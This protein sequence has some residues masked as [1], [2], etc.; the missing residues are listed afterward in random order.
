MVSARIQ[1]EAK[2]LSQSRSELE[3]KAKKARRTKSKIWTQEE[4]DLFNAEA[5]ELLSHFSQKPIKG[6]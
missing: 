3:R 5:T 1:I 6:N 2:R 4:N